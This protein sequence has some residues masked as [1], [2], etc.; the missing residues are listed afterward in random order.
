MSLSARNLLRGPILAF[1]F[2]FRR[3]ATLIPALLLVVPAL[4]VAVPRAMAQQEPDFYD[5]QPY[6]PGQWDIG[7]QLNQSE[8]RY[9]VDPRDPSWQV[10]GEIGDAIAQSLLLQP[11][12]YGVPSEFVIEDLTKVYAILLQDCDVYMGF[13]LIP[14]GYPDWVTLT[15]TYDQIGY[16]Y[17]TAKPELH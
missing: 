15:R 3:L 17:V 6:A 4:L 2:P 12:R 14:D 13:K 16:E 5:D 1:A 10:D 7:R 11:K 9:C 8:F